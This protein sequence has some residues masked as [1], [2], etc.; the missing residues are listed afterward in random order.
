MADSVLNII[1]FFIP[2]N[3][4]FLFQILSKLISPFPCLAI[5]V[6]HSTPE[7]PFQLQGVAD[8]LSPIK[9]AAFDVRQFRDA[10]W[11]LK[12]PLRKLQSA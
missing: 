2:S 11:N 6:P 12:E 8:V 7:F 3:N 9:E 4:A 5:L 10:L 1:V